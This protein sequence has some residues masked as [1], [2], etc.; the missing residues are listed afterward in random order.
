MNREVIVRPEAKQDVRDAAAWYRGISPSL[1]EAFIA[2]VDSALA[3][4]SEQPE[5]FQV[6][7]RSFRRILL[8][9]FPYALFYLVTSR[10]IVVAGILHQAR[11]P[12]VI[13]GRE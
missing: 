2:A 1:G 9:R 12:R 6:V 7:Y 8:R 4:A 13:L 11:D 5:A 3:V 10:S